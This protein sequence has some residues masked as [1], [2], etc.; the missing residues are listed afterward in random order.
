MDA[1][2][3]VF[4]Q[5]VI[6]LSRWCKRLLTVELASS[7]SKRR[8]SLAIVADLR[9]FVVGCWFLAGWLLAEQL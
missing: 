3:V 9:H 6:R 8:S 4:I 5:E 2:L 7:L 1:F